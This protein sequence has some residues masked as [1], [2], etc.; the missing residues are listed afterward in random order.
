LSRS[1]VAFLF[2]DP[3]VSRVRTDPDPQNAR[4][5]ASFRK[6]G[7]REVGVVETPDGLVMLRRA[8]RM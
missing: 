3:R 6:A 5:V 7:F 1:F 8:T 4:A 2:D